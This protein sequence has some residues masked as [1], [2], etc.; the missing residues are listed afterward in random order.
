MTTRYH[1]GQVILP[2]SR[3][4]GMKL[5]SHFTGDREGNLVVSGVCRSDVLVVQWH[6]PPNYSCCD[7]PLSA[8]PC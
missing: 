2:I 3:E 5:M 7:L 6:A 1:Q 8:L 4:G